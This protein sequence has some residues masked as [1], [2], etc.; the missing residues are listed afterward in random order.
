VNAAR[1]AGPE[2][3][4]GPARPSIFTALA[5]QLGLRLESRKGPVPVFVIEKIEKPGKN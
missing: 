2:T 4:N 3:A 1:P 5:E